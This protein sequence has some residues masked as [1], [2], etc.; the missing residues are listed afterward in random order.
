MWIKES[1]KF[2]G[3]LQTR[4]ARHPHSR[5]GTTQ[6][7]KKETTKQL[8][9]RSPTSFLS[10]AVPVWECHTSSPNPQRRQEIKRENLYGSTKGS[11]ELFEDRAIC[12][13]TKTYMSRYSWPDEAC[14]CYN[15]SSDTTR[16]IA[17]SH[18]VPLAHASLFIQLIDFNVRR[19]TFKS[20]DSFF[21]HSWFAW[22]TLVILF[23]SR[24]STL[25]FHW[26]HFN[27]YSYLLGITASVFI[28]T[29]ILVP[30]VFATPPDVGLMSHIRL[31]P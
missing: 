4:Q 12:L 29:R 2:R 16:N 24:W 25:F 9:R 18:W 7:G 20:L 1:E 30:F 8:K 28:V 10:C 6:E 5:T 26:I 23:N 19:F 13:R 21:I 14:S 3:G 17:K 22:C 11:A 27:L 31:S 15:K